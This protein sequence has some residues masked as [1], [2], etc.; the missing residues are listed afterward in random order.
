MATELHLAPA[1]ERLLEIIWANAP[2]RSAEITKMAQQAFGWGKS[3]TYTL[4]RRTEDKGVIKSEHATVTV[5][6]SRE[7]Y[8]SGR[9]RHFVNHRFGGSLPAFVASFIGDT[10][11]SAER[12]D[13][14]I[15][16]I[17]AHKEGWPQKGG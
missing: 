10:K 6:V 17:Q 7:S 8:L 14:L 4:L 13:E 11:L 2:I 3:T 16:L 1:E 9:S 12:A 5:L 15:R